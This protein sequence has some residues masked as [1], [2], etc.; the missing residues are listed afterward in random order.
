MNWL[1]TTL[2]LIVAGW[3]RKR[4]IGLIPILLLAIWAVAEVLSRY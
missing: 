1:R 4:T 2:Q 3:T